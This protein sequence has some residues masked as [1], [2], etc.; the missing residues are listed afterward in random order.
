MKTRKFDYLY[1]VQQF[2]NS[3]GWEDVSAAPQTIQ[4]RKEMRDDLKAYRTN[5]PEYQ[6]RMIRRREANANAMSAI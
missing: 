2:T 6:Y 4:G 1:V 3:Y 5:A